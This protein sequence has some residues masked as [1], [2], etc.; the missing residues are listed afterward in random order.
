MVSIAI[1]V[2]PCD[3]FIR[4][5]SCQVYINIST[6]LSFLN[7]FDQISVLYNYGPIL[8]HSISKSTPLSLFHSYNSKISISWIK[9]TELILSEKKHF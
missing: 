1:I 7:L 8:I 5:F 4:L 3:I 2:F 6:I 9:D